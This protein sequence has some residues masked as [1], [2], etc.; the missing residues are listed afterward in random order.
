LLVAGGQIGFLPAA[1]ASDDT[2]GVIAAGRRQRERSRIA[3]ADPEPATP[4]G[5]ASNA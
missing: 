2:P 4:K 3:G 1:S 5:C